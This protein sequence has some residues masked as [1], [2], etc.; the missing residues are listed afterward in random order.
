MP[1]EISQSIRI[2]DNFSEPLKNLAKS[3]WDADD[4]ILAVSKSF[5]EQKQVMEEVQAQAAGYTM[6]L[7]T[8]LVPTLVSLK[9]DAVAVK[10]S[11]SEMWNER[12]I[13]SAIEFAGALG[14]LSENV[15]SSASSAANWAIEFAKVRFIINNKNWFLAAGVAP[16]AAKKMKD[17]YLHIFNSIMESVGNSIDEI[18]ISDKLNT[19]FGEAGKVAKD[20]AYELANQIGESATM[21]TELSARAAYEGIGTDQFEKMM[22]LA[23][24][25]SKLKPGESV[26]NVANSLISNIKSGHDAGSIAQMFGGGQVM[27]RQLKRAGYERALN[28]GDV[29]KAL[30]IAEKIAEQAGLTDEK[31]G[32][33]FSNMSQNYKQILNVIDNIKKRFGETYNRAFAPTVQKIKELVT[34]DRFQ[35]IVNVI[36]KIIG[37]IGKAVN[38]LVEGLID[39]IHIFGTLLGIGVVAKTMILIKRFGLILKLLKFML[40]V[41]K[42]FGGPITWIIKQLVAIGVKQSLILLKSKA[43][44]AVK[45]AGPWLA[46][47]GVITGVLYALHKATGVAGTFKGFLA[48]IWQAAIN[49]FTN[50]I[51]WI[52]RLIDHGKILKLRIESFIVHIVQKVKQSVAPLLQ[53]LARKFQDFLEWSKIGK[54]LDFFEVDWRGMTNAIDDWAEGLGSEEA[55]KLAKIQEEIRK[56]QVG[57]TDYIDTSRGIK[58]AIET[59]GGSIIDGIKKGL[60]FDEKQSKSQEGIQGDTNKIR[61]TMDQEEELRWLKAFSDRQIMSSYNQSTS[62]TSTVYFNRM[63]EQSQAAAMRRYNAI[64]PRNAKVAAR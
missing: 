26:E 2:E 23:D 57:M 8:N 9:D 19:M 43:I 62:N 1:N 63:S 34:S 60:G 64:P 51:I 55:D 46:V 7:V 6:E 13:S 42:L 53:W 5:T 50:V 12:T 58:E 56:I 41:L 36:N 16:A 20:R 54:V 45:M 4:A 27:E 28:R 40:P 32:D 22:H 18:T 39:N 11:F 44:A 17:S 30:E 59:E 52:D 24:K 14:Q 38:W 47:A 25:V 37:L 61:S 21:V 31:Y 29:N 3:V 10:D 35:K 49:G 48:G 33:A 15:A